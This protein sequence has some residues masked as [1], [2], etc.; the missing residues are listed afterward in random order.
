MQQ[1]ERNAAGTTA[2][3]P[4]ATV[5]AE[6][7]LVVASRTPRWWGEACRGVRGVWHP[8]PQTRASGQTDVRTGRMPLFIGLSDCAHCYPHLAPL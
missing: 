1:A 5:D 3:A 2:A 4:A 7:A 6:Q 8:A